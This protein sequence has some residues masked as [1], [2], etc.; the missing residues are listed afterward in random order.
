MAY[1]ILNIVCMCEDV[2]SLIF[3]LAF[4]L[5]K[6][7]SRTWKIFLW[8]KDHFTDYLKILIRNDYLSFSQ[9]KIKFDIL[10]YLISRVK[11]IRFNQQFTIFIDVICIL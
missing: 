4:E 7:N 2:Y 3:P 10:K 11:T 8:Y 5:F 9:L 1:Y 6:W